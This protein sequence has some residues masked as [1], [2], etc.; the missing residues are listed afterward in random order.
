MD[1]SG[2]NF[3][4]SGMLC[5]ICVC[6]CMTCSGA[7]PSFRKDRVYMAV[8]WSTTMMTTKNP[9]QT[10]WEWTQRKLTKSQWDQTECDT[11]E[12]FQLTVSVSVP[13]SPS[14]FLSE[15]ESV[16][17]SNPECIHC[18]CCLSVIATASIGINEHSAKV[19]KCVSEIA[20]AYWNGYMFLQW[21]TL[22]SAGVH[23]KERRRW[24]KWFKHHKGN[25]YTMRSTALTIA[26]I[27]MTTIDSNKIELPFSMA[28]PMILV[29][30]QSANTCTYTP[31]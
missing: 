1:F 5:F 3:G 4:N 15:R 16:C 17:Q 7:M 9:Y 20:A 11:Y 28:L 30:R 24:R 2:T 14:L 10:K 6:V 27:H 23:T 19:F 22:C 13:L 31:R 12:R 18:R 25:K 21:I 29:C 26:Y 8:I